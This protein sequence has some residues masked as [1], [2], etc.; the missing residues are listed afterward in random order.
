MF[1]F[2]PRKR[3][4]S[5]LTTQENSLKRK[6][7]T[8]PNKTLS[9][10]SKHVDCLSYDGNR[11]NAQRHFLK[12]DLVDY[13]RKRRK[14]VEVNRRKGNTSTKC[15]SS[16]EEGEIRDDDTDVGEAAEDVS[17][18]EFPHQEVD[19][20][21][22]GHELHVDSMPNKRWAEEYES[23]ANVFKRRKENKIWDSIWKKDSHKCTE[24]EYLSKNNKKLKANQENGTKRKKLI[25]VHVDKIPENVHKE[26]QK[27]HSNSDKKRQVSCEEEAI[28]RLEEAKSITDKEK[29]ITCQSAGQ[30]VSMERNM[31]TSKQVMYIIL[32]LQ[33][34]RG[35]LRWKMCNVKSD[36]FYTVTVFA[37]LCAA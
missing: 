20:Y 21:H 24:T 11:V 30:R 1:F 13:S 7:V 16:E 28:T 17:N 18:K 25:D 31:P 8:S 14:P 32:Y 29:Q 10:K 27:Y 19:R 5:V 22:A 6:S 12:G 33:V 9:S 15:S 3:N 4:K 35:V 26:S 34:L 36:R 37:V 23:G 2:Y